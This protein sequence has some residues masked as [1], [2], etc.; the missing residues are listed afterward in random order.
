MTNDHRQPL[1]DARNACVRFTI[2]AK[3]GA[4]RPYPRAEPLGHVERING[5]WTAWIGAFDR[6]TTGDT[7]G[8]AAESALGFRAD[9]IAEAFL[10]SLIARH[11]DRLDDIRL[12]IATPWRGDPNALGGLCTERNLERALE[13]TVIDRRVKEATS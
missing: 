2:T 5:K 11:P 6:W 4:I 9:R 3:T 13:A 12:A 10:A 8:G 7:K 1:I